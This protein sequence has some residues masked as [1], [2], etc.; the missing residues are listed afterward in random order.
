MAPKV[1]T[2]KNASK[3]FSPH[4]MSDTDP[5]PVVSMAVEAL[6]K[7]IADAVASKRQSRAQL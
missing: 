4:K 1:L 5:P 3:A 2:V 6:E 7:M